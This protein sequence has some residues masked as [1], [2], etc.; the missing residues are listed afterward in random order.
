MSQKTLKVSPFVHEQVMELGTRL[1]TT[2]SGAILHLLNDTSLAVP[3]EPVQRERWEAAAAEWG[4]SLAQFVLLRVEATL[5]GWMPP[6]PAP[7][8]APLAPAV[9]GACCAPPF[10]V[11]EP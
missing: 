5:G 7:V 1:D 9:W 8:P 4:V 3:L 2:A 11:P 10:E 6:D